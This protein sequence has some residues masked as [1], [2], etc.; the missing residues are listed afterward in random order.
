MAALTDTLNLSIGDQVPATRLASRTYAGAIELHGKQVFIDLTSD[1]V[2]A[3]GESA[4]PIF[5]EIELYF[6]CLVRKQV[7]FREIDTLSVDDRNHAR[8]MAGFFA[9][10]RAVSTQQCRISDVGD[11]PPVETMPVHKPERFVP[12]WIKIDYRHDQWIGEYGFKR[13]I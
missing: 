12:D 10:F 8:V 13:T 2:R 11:K 9:G 4:F 5:C 3:V 7:R 1:A 6:S